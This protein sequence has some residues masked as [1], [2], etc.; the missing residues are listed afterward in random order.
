MEKGSNLAKVY[1]T[2]TMAFGAGLLVF[3]TAI[4]IKIFVTMWCKQ[5]SIQSTAVREIEERKKKKKVTMC[6]LAVIAT[7]IVCYIPQF[8]L[9][10]VEGYSKSENDFKNYLKVTQ[11]LIALN[12]A[13]DPFLFSLQGSDFKLL[14]RKFIPCKSTN[15]RTQQQR[16]NTVTSSNRETRNTTLTLDEQ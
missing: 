10:I 15:R 3:L 5:S 4:S 8:V 12:S 9:K 14:V 2:A 1:F 11:F 13:L 6:V 16:A 7:Y